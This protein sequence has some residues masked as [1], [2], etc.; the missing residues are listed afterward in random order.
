MDNTENFQ[1]K[2]ELLSKESLRH[3]MLVGDFCC[4]ADNPLNTFLSDDAFD[5]AEEKQGHTYILMDNEYTCIL[6]FYTIKANAIHTFNIDTNEYMALPVVEIARIAVYF[7]FQGNGLG[8]ILFY[9]Y[10]IPKIKK[11]S[12][13]IAIYGIIVF[14]ES[15]NGQGIQFYNSLGFKRANNEIQKAVGDSYNEKCELY[16]LKLDDIKE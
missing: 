15:E 5:Y 1:Y 16:V 11:V 3:F 2:E 9:D 6:A 7:D 14:V 10:I 12:K 13:I 4:G 8:K